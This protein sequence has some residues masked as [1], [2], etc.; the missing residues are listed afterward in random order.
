MAISEPKSAHLREVLLFAFNW[1]KSATEAYRMLEEVYGDHALSKSQ[2]YRW[3]KIFQSGNFELDNE[4]RGKPPQKFEDAELTQTQEK[5]AKQLQ[6]S[7]V[8]V[9][10]RLNSLGMTQKLSRWAP[11]ELSER[12][13]ERRLV[14][15]KGL[16][17]RHE[18][19]SFLHRI[20][21][22]DEKWIN[23]SNPTRQKSWGLPG[24]FPKQT[25]R[26]NCFGKKAML[27]VWWDQTGVVYFEFLKPGETAVNEK[28]P[29]W[30]EKHNKLILQHDNAPAQNAT[31]VKNTIKDLSWEL[32]PHPLYS[33]DLAPSDYHLFTSLGHALKKQEF[34]NSD[35]L[36][37]WLVDWFDS[38]GIEFF[39]QGIRKLPERLVLQLAVAGL[40]LENAGLLIYT[41]LEDLNAYYSFIFIF[42][43]GFFGG[44]T[45]VLTACY[46]VV[47]DSSRL[48]VRANRYAALEFSM[49][50]GLPLGMFLGGAIFKLGGY[51]TVF[52]ISALL[53]V[54]AEIWT[55]FIIHETLYK[56]Q[57]MRWS[58]DD[59]F[60]GLRD[61]FSCVNLRRS[62]HTCFKTRPYNFKKQIWLLIGGMAVLIM[63]IMG[64][65]T[66]CG[67]K[68]TD[69]TLM[70]FIYG[71]S[72]FS[73]A[74][75]QNQLNWSASK[76]SMYQAVL[77][78]VQA[79]VLVATVPLLTN[80]LA[81]KEGLLGMLGTSSLAAQLI[82]KSF[83]TLEW[84]YFYAYV[85]GL[86]GGAARIASRTRI[87]KLVG[88][89]E[90]GRSYSDTPIPQGITEY[91]QHFEE[92]R[93]CKGTSR[94]PEFS[95]LQRACSV[96]CA[97]SRKIFSVLALCEVAVPIGSNL[98]FTKVYSVT[99]QTFPGAPYL[100]AFL[101]LSIPMVIFWLVVWT[102]C[103]LWGMLAEFDNSVVLAGGPTCRLWGMLAEFDNSAVLAGG[104]T[105]RLWGM[106]AE[107]DNSV[108]LAGGP[109]CRLWGM[110]AEFDNSV[111]LAGGPT[112]RLWGMLAEFDN[113]AVLAG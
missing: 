92:F 78:L 28:R 24:Q 22:S 83:S 47:T 64:I 20:V 112:C 43:S 72:K 110:L 18:K 30:R 95:S 90:L 51:R 86:L 61:L 100:A 13:Q 6:V 107:F 21:T 113:S 79:V 62:Y 70:L 25:P 39:R 54:L 31:V 16:L 10:L 46:S 15:R 85:A 93:Y 68:L 77:H 35:I 67:K 63:C 5:L 19:K 23:F 89:A 73:F 37:K 11:H 59:M 17:A 2:C 34:S 4:P 103:R 38:K 87:S 111:V 1:K 102:T 105:C 65:S 75:T 94:R 96:R 80:K 57:K 3:Y 74:F 66:D 91:I 60:V 52:G 8:A 98:I 97:V 76:Y 40:L 82:I 53:Y 12:Q 49:V 81:I 7:Q 29:E 104:P 27:C 36:R 69:S 26:P 45:L 42:P 106:L 99:M 101:L 44:L 84:V 56:P 32:L 14:T 88:R 58:L 48:A 33:P 9:S 50:L 41:A 71:A 109:T 55:R 108:V